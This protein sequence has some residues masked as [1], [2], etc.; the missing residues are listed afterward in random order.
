MLNTK[1]KVGKLDIKLK[2]FYLSKMHK[3][4][5]QAINLKVI[6]VPHTNDKV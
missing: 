1:E 5:R 2:N 3:V 4:K 6:F